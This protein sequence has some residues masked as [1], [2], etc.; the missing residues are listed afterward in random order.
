M[1][2]RRTSSEELPLITVCLVGASHSRLLRDHGTD[3]LGEE[4]RKHIEFVYVLATHPEHF[5]IATIAADMC[6]YVVLGFGQWTHSYTEHQHPFTNSK[7]RR[8]LQR[9]IT[10]STLP[11]FLGSA[12]TFVRSMNYNGLGA[13][14]TVCPPQDYRQPHV[15]DFYN[16][17]QRNLSAALGVGYIDTN[18]IMG[19]L[20]DSA[21][22]WNHPGARVYTAEA[23]HI[24]FTVL[25]SSAQ[26]GRPIVPVKVSP[27]RV[28]LRFRSEETVYLYQ[29]GKLRRF[30]DSR[31][32]AGMGFAQSDVKALSDRDMD[33]FGLGTDIPKLM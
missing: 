32:L 19:P 14:S 10:E 33:H 7:S 25:S 3:A 20:W 23:E 15:V 17:M 24:L 28:L 31:T 21:A 6:T 2:S 13:L 29:D 16:A 30:P 5:S 9:I 26:S 27:S 1:G 8:E 22:D 4:G 11:L 18:H 12:Q